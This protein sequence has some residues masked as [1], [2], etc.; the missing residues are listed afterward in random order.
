MSEKRPFIITFI[1]DVSIFSAFLVILSLFPKF[2]GRF[3]IYFQALDYYWNVSDL[4]KN[5]M[6]VLIATILFTVAYGYLRLKRWGYWLMICINLLPLLGWLI[7]W[8][9]N[10]HSVFLNPIMTFITLAF[11]LPTAKYFVTKTVESQSLKE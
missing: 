7:S 3:G 5:V 1:G 11:V 9:Q 8:G 4:T 2:L 10:K 6:T